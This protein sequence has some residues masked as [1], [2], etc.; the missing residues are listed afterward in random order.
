MQK[1]K[2][3]NCITITTTTNTTTS[4]LVRLHF[5]TLHLR[6]RHLYTIYI[7]NFYKLK[8]SFSPI[9]NTVSVRIH[10]GSVK[11]PDAFVLPVWSV[12]SLVSVTKI[13]F[14]V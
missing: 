9:L 14:C 4:T 6:R 8:D 12:R 10:F 11:R 13:A 5:L 1:T 7:A 3:Q 2:I